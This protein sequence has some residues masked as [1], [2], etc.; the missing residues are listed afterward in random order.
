MSA[1][2]AE[3]PVTEVMAEIGRNARIGARA[4]AIATSEQKRTALLTAAGAINAHRKGG[5]DGT[6]VEA[7]LDRTGVEPHRSCAGKKSA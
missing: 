4:L 3:K 2:E 1:L 7:D 5:P 6:D